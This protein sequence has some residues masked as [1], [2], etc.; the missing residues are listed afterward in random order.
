MALRLGPEVQID[1]AW[2]N[3]RRLV[4][5]VDIQ[6]PAHPI[7]PDDHAALG[8]QRTPAEPSART[9]RRHRSVVSVGNLD[10]IDDIVR[11][12]GKGNHIRIARSIVPSYS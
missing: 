5:S 10:Q 6:D 9:A 3:Q 1:D 7:H 12:R 11:I 2:L 4:L 8:R